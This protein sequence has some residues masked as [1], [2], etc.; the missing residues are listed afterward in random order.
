[1]RR[2]ADAALAADGTGRMAV[3]GRAVCDL[4]VAASGPARRRGLLGRD[5][6]DGAILIARANSVH[7]VGMAFPIDVAFLDRRLRVLRVVTMPPGRLGL[8]RLRARH[9][10]E[11]AAG[12]CAGW[13][14]VP[15]A[16]LSVDLS[17]RTPG[18]V[19]SA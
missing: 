19:S 14:V 11:T 12:A 17:P 15:G 18:S 3:E 9:V 10:L 8:P 16:T 1:M 13:G 5:S 7:T 4:E 6:L 2:R